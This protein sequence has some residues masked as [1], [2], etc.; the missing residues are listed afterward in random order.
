MMDLKQSETAEN[1]MRAFAGESQARNR[2]TF[3]ASTA[4]KQGLPVIEEVF[5]FTAGQEKEHGEIFYNYL[6]ELRGQNMPV[7][8]AYPLDQYEETLDLLKAAR[9][10]EFEEYQE[11]YKNFGNV[12]KAEGFTQ[13]ANSF[14][15]IAEIERTHGERFQMFAD[16]MER[17][18]LFAS[19]V[20]TGWMCLNC[21]YVYEGTQAPKEC[22]VCHHEQGY[23]IRL[24]LAPYVR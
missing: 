14:F 19:E 4:K 13:I 18:H 8:G 10:N 7:D 12:A 16:Y 20:E 21:G 11:I 24:E 15:M 6:K 5:L 22:P 1:L 17:N 2:Y 9:H 3:A 23:F